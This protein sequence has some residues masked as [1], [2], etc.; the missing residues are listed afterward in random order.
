M[1][2]EEIINALAQLEEGMNVPYVCVIPVRM[3]EAWLL[4]D[5]NAIR[6]AAGNQYGRVPLTLPRARDLEGIADPKALLFELLRTASELTGRRL[7]RLSL[8][9]V[10]LR[11]AQLIDDFAAL[12]ALRA[13]RLFEADLGEVV[14]QSHWA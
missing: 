4:I 12:R 13:F 5:Q 10:R 2:K 6:M 8:S 14:T 7:Q 1:R 3:Q 9:G 11:I